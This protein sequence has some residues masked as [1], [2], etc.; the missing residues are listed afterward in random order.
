MKDFIHRRE[1]QK[2]KHEATKGSASLKHEPWYRKRTILIIAAI[3]TVLI[4]AATVTIILL[5]TAANNTIGQIESAKTTTANQLQQ[6]QADYENTPADERLSRVQQF[7]GSIEIV[8][9]KATAS[10][11]WF[12]DAQ[13]RCQDF[14]D[15]SEALMERMTKLAHLLE[16]DIYTKKQFSNV[17]ASAE[18]T[19]Y[20]AEVEKWQAIQKA[21]DEAPYKDLVGDAH[22]QLTAKVSDIGG[23]WQQLVKASEEENAGSFNEANNSLEEKYTA[24]Q[25]VGEDIT[26][27][28]NAAQ[29]EALE[30]Y[31]AYKN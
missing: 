28:Y 6:L 16:Y 19:D 5:N 14:T 9:C 24:L 7:A 25:V 3:V 2:A 15:K 30:A 22:T 13:K 29:Y 21:L 27:A 31:Q 4:I 23:T 11:P 17:Q 26:K 8:D 1:R 10:L 12:A 18:I 20:A